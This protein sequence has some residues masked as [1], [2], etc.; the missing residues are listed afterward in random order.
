MDQ[1]PDS[2]RPTLV[3]FN[4]RHSF[5]AEVCWSCSDQE[6]GRWVPVTDCPAARSQMSDDSGSLYADVVIFEKSNWPD[7]EENSEH[8]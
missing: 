4:G 2:H 6:T 3:H 5:P 1:S 7:N 8:E